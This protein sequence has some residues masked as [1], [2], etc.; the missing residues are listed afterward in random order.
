MTNRKSKAVDK[1]SLAKVFSI[2]LL[3]DC[4]ILAL[5]ESLREL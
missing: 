5:V 4:N 2:S 1:N 3:D